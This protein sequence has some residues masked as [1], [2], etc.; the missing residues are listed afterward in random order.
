MNPITYRNVVLQDDVEAI[1]VLVAGSGVF[2]AEEI[3]VAVELAEDA[4][5][6][7]ETSGYHFILAEVAGRLMGYSCFGRIPLTQ[8]RYDL[9][10]IVV[11][12]NA[13]QQGV[14]SGILRK[15]ETAIKEV[16]GKIVY[17]ET[18]SRIIY[19]PAQS[20]YVKRG[21]KELAR[22]KDFYSNGDDKLIYGKNL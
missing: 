15:T 12:G 5:S 9:Y 16:G 3:D 14:A 22:L 20:F 18:S 10:W 11:D 6:H 21:F 13:Q 4:L 17:A 7:K 2:S 8:E 1:H 19:A